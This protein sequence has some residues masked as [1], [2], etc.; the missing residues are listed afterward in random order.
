[1]ALHYYCSHCGT[2]VGSLDSISIHSE[3]LGLHKLTDAE[4]HDMISYVDNGDIHI[5]SICEDCQ[6]SLE[7]N[8]G[9][10]ENDFLI[11]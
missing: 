5:K 3:S 2:K 11:H 4:R 7:R 6:E 10:H 9:Y 8:P 1:M